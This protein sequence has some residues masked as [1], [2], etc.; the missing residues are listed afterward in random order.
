MARS[1]ASAAPLLAIRA[2][3]L[4]DG[5]RSRGRGML[6][7]ENGIITDLDTTGAAPPLSADVIDLGGD[8]W[9]LPGLID[10]HVHLALDASGDPVQAVM[11]GDD[12]HILN[13]MRDAALSALQAGITT[14][15]D[16]GDRQY[17]ALT[18]REEFQC[19][20]TL[21]PEIVPAGPPITTSGGHC[22]FLGGEAESIA[23]IRAA[24]RER[25]ERGCQVVKVMASGGFLT[26]RSAP[27]HNQYELAA[28]RIAVAESHRF[29]LPTAAHVHAETSILDCL[30]AGFDSLEHVT[31]IPSC[32]EEAAS[33]IVTRIARQGVFIS[34]TVGV[35][36]VVQP[37]P[38]FVR[39]QPRKTSF[40]KKLHRAG[41]SIIASTDAGISPGKPHNILPYGIAALPSY[42]LTTTEAL[43]AATA[44][45]AKACGLD[46][47]KGQL[48][49]GADADLLAVARSPLADLAALRD[50]R[51]V[52]RAGQLV[53][54]DG[55]AP[56]MHG[57]AP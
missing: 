7:I 22:H 25:V 55:S 40:L 41:A 35:L 56:V 20:G 28:L 29:G 12:A 52:F 45:A 9:L 16:L 27:D 51:A 23:E 19:R 57:R 17:L 5:L 39:H 2:G 31:F 43:R 33:S 53:P 8:G 37:P 24:V 13:R 11:R 26:P 46:G 21:G 3:N 47:S 6:L 38:E 36:P 42:G 15:R 48:R 50:V 18:L 14:V 54:A 44:H 32:T 4:F 30:N 10:A 49:A 1:Q 34:P